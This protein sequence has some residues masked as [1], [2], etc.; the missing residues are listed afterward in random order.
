[1]AFYGLFYLGLEAPLYK[2]NIAGI[3]ASFLKLHNSTTPVLSI[4][5]SP[6]I[7]KYMRLGYASDYSA[8]APLA[9]IPH[10]S[11]NYLKHLS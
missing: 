10:L 6:L 3:C 5:V 11:T 9:I 7:Y 2:S 8:I 4:S 1:M